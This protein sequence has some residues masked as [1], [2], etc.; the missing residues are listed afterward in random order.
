LSSESPA[1]ACGSFTTRI[2]SYD[3]GIWLTRPTAGSLFAAV[4]ELVHEDEH[5]VA[6]SLLDVCVHSLSPAGHGATLVWFPTGAAESGGTLDT[7][8]AYSP[9][10]LSVLD[11]SHGAAIAQGLSQLDR[12][13]V[14]DRRGE[15]RLVNV[16][17]PDDPSN[18][19]LAFAGGTRHNS[20]GRYSAAVPAAVLF[21][22]SA[23]GPVTVFHRGAI[24]TF[25]E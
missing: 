7:N 8:A 10:A 13:V 16:T 25:L 5:D 9:P 22:V 6:R 23:D 17:L 1:G 19:D 11:G 3:D 20:A 12:A 14:I 21:V 18:R 15:V 24:V 2:F 4:S